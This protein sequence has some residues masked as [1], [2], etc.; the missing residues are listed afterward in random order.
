MLTRHNGG[1]RKGAGRPKGSLS[2]IT[3]AARDVAASVLDKVDASAVW[4]RLIRSSDDKTVANVMMY[5]TD[6]VYGKPA[7]RIEGNPDKPVSIVLKWGG[8]TVEW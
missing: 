4:E 1:A 2:S 3:V 6:R 5:L 7:Q 8:P